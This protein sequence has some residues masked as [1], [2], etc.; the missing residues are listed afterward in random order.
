MTTET[1]PTS[2]PWELT[3]SKYWTKMLKV[4]PFRIIKVQ[5]SFIWTSRVR[6]RIWKSVISTSL[7]NHLRWTTGTRIIKLRRI[8]GCPRIRWPPQRSNK[9]SNQPQTVPSPCTC[10][11]KSETSH[12]TKTKNGFIKSSKAN[13]NARH[14]DR[15]LKSFSNW[16][17][18]SLRI[19]HPITRR[20]KSSTW[21]I[22][23]IPFSRNRI[24]AGSWICWVVGRTAPLMSRQ[25]LRLNS[26]WSDRRQS[27]TSKNN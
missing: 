13:T 12:S 20:C 27:F 2:T 8:W 16:M 3:P 21:R 22:W 1:T 4:W 26:R 15:R 6:Y 24:W 9:I 18:M 14:S 23:I 7:W 25:W 17:T 19:F 10:F 11:A 5:A